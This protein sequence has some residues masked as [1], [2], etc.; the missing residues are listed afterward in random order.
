[1]SKQGSL[2]KRERKRFGAEEYSF[3]MRKV[4]E[5]DRWTC[6][7]PFCESSRNLTV[8]H[9]VKRSQLGGDELGNLITLCFSCHQAVERHELEIEVVDVV[10]KFHLKGGR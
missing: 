2:S 7:N 5:R 8:H 6:R 9:I 4:F 10:A 3:L 1:M